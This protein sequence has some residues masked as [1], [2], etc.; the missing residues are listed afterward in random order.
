[1]PRSGI[2]FFIRLL[3]SLYCTHDV[4]V[5]HLRSFSNTPR[6]RNCLVVRRVGSLFHALRSDL[7]IRS[8]GRHLSYTPYTGNC[9]ISRTV[10]SLCVAPRAKFCLVVFRVGNFSYMLSG[11]I[12]FII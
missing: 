9:L 3:G 11:A 2:R 6:S 10:D 8:S 7:S 12:F 4:V 1:M 5:R